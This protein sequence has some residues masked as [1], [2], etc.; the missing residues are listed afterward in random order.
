M[1]SAQTY[2]EIKPLVDFCKA[3]KL[4]EA[5]EWIASG[6]PVNLPLIR[7]KKAGRQSPLQIAMELGFHSL[8]KVLLD[9]GAEMEERYSPLEHAIRK[10]RLDLVK[11]LMEKGTNIRSVDITTV[12]DAWNPEMVEYFIDQGADLETRN[13]VAWALCAKIRPALGLIKRYQDRFPSFHEQ[14]NI[15]LRHHCWEGNLKWVSLML[16]AGADPYARGPDSPEQEADPEEDNNALE[17]A[18][19]HG[20]LDIFKL[21]AIR[22]DPKRADSRRLVEHACDAENSDVLKMLLE[23]GFSP[24]D[25]EDKGSSLIYSLLS[26]MS[27][28]W[29]FNPFSGARKIEKDLDSDRSRENIKMIHMLARHGARWKPE[30]QREINYVRRSLLKMTADYTVEFVWIMSKYKACAREHI[31]QLLRPAPMRILTQKHQSRLNEL[32]ANLP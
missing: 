9:G 27:F 5:Q 12:F 18:A 4:F 31:E 3:G 24:G 14:A 8:V 32:I 26:G 7:E 22:L 29:D 23:R 1:K 2:E 30:S 25:W 11:L 21:K 17:N 15:A 13:P 6:K 19:F 16:W 20:R 28:D 10:R